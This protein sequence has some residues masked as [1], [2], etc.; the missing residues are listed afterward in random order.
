MPNSHCVTASETLCRPTLVCTSFAL[1]FYYSSVRFRCHALTRHGPAII[2]TAQH[3]RF[4]K[5]LMC[6]S[7][8]SVLINMLNQAQRLSQ[9][10][11]CLRFEQPNIFYC[12]PK[13]LFSGHV[14][15]LSLTICHQ[16]VNVSGAFS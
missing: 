14:F 16:F 11:L 4:L 12:M 1:L 7:G 5:S 13:L 3:H 2:H 9:L 8:D 6:D 10:R 15:F